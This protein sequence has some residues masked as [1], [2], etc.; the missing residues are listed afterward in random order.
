MEKNYVIKTNDELVPVTKEVY[1]A[2]YRSKRKERY[3]MKDLKT[4]RTLLDEEN[5]VTGYRP[6]RERSLDELM[7]KGMDFPDK[8]P[9]VESQVFQNIDRDI[10]RWAIRQLKPEHQK[11]VYA[12]YYDQL[13]ES[14]YAEKI[15]NSQSSVN[16]MKKTVLKKLKKLLEKTL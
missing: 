3:F 5:Q 11:L 13:T 15:G 12:L 7:E 6:A 8:A 10:V 14:E 16:Q 4:T 9:S 1:Y 2:Y